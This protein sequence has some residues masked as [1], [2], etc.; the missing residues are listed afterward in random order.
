MEGISNAD[1]VAGLKE[2]LSQGSNAAVAKLG[3]ENGFLE[4]P[5][6]KI[7]LPDTLKQ[8]D[9][10]MRTFGMG[11]QADEL[12]VAM[13]RAAEAAVP[14]AKTLLLDAVK[15]MT[16]QDAKY[17]LTGGDDAATQYFRKTTE[18]PL[19]VK[20]LPIVKKATEKVGLAEK[21]NEFAGT[22]AK[23]GLVSEGDA[24]LENYVT[25]KTL[26]GLFVMVADEEKAIRQNPVQAA[27]SLAQ[28]I[29]GALGK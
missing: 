13:N 8:V 19:T 23:F 6:V 10:A 7:P 22:G 12:V 16:V 2:A 24:K 5:K 20:F 26:D 1:A 27:G 18:S 28:K 29:F 4:N 3:L 14:E 11:K 25:R 17:I 9:R 21:Y 15:K